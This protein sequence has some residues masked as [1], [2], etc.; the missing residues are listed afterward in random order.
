[1]Q[2]VSGADFNFFNGV[3]ISQFND[4]ASLFCISLSNESIQSGYSS[5][6]EVGRL[7]LLLDFET[8]STKAIHVFVLGCYFDSV[9]LNRAG[10]VNLSYVVGAW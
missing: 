1:M 9:T 10:Q 6:I 7:D 8:A 5:V 2:N 3:D 4:G